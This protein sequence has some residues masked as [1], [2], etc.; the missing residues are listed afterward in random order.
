M[1]LTNYRPEIDGLR[2]IAV[3]S[4]ILYHG[5]INA[6]SGGYIGVDIFFVISGY[7]ITRI[8]GDAIAAGTFSFADFFE[9]RAR[10]ILPALFAML[11]VGTV[12]GYI[13]LSPNQL[14][15]FSLS[16]I[17]VTGFI[18]NH[19]FLSKTGYFSPDAEELPLL[20]TWTLSV[21]EQ[22]YIVIPILML[23]LW[24]IRPRLM[25]VGLVGLLLL[26]LAICLRWEHHGS[27]TRGF[28]LAASR[29]WEFLAGALLSSSIE[30]RWPRGAISVG[31]ANAFATLGLACIALPVTI[32]TDKTPYPGV[33]TIAPVLGTTLI[34]YFATPLTYVGKLLS[35]RPFVAIGLASYSAYL[36]HQPLLAFFRVAIGGALGNTILTVLLIA[37]TLL[38]FI[39]WRFVERPFRHPA[40]VSRRS[41]AIFGVTGTLLLASVG[42]GLWASDGLPGRYSSAQ[43]ELAKSSSPSP[44]RGKCEV[45]GVVNMLPQNACRYFGSTSTWAVFG[46]SHAVEIS[47]ALAEHL[48][49]TNAGGVLQLAASGCQPALTFETMVVGCRIWNKRSIDYIA[50]DKNITDVALAYRHG[51][52]LYG[53]QNRTYPILPDEHP[54]FL[55]DL[56]ADE[57]RE[58]YWQSFVLIIQQLIASGK[59]V[60]VIEPIPELGRPVEWNIYSPQIGMARIDRSKGTDFTYYMGRNKFIIDKIRTLQTGP[61]LKVVQTN[62]AFCK[63]SACFA[64]SNGKSLYFDDNHLSL[65][66][67]ERV[68]KLMLQK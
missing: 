64:L 50:R 45:E 49:D 4:V 37:I 60:H 3:C 21:E 13:L 43:A 32:F 61:Q 10:R 58:K 66:G 51:L 14:K 48:R 34:I 16:L 1:K 15:E 12:L 41:I 25:N 18:S 31:T 17:S 65:I 44:M 46:D 27:L 35:S 7:L 36:W 9:R 67:A 2:C 63:N 42:Y 28:F 33:A 20:H 19:Y 38:S 5:N 56:S 55:Y 47:Y 54:N 57:A 22:F 40:K 11:S 30:K 68:V 62:Q 53:R 8:I 23:V 24:K 39:S 59:V 52:Y 26:S 6:F 29:A